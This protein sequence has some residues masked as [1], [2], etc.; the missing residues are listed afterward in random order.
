MLWCGL[1]YAMIA[2]CEDIYV[3]TWKTLVQYCSC[4]DFGLAMELLGLELR[5][6]NAMTLGLKFQ[7]K[8]I[9]V[10]MT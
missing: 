8:M 6:V 2:I 4:K 1:P 9:T 10:L 3:M 5:Q 7:T